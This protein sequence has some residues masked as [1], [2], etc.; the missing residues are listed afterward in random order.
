MKKIITIVLSFLMILNIPMSHVHADNS[1][2][3]IL[4]NFTYEI[5]ENAKFMKNVATR[6]LNLT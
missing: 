1:V 3:Q 5:F 2:E 6:S 4:D